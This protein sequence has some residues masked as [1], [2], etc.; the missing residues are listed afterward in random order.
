MANQPASLLETKLQPPRARESLVR[1]R[2]VDLADRVLDVPLALVSAPAGFGKSTVMLAW[3]ERLSASAAVAWIS[4]DEAD[5]EPDHF[6]RY[7]AEAAH[8][9]WEITVG[10]ELTLEALVVELVN[11][12]AALDRPAVLMLDDYQLVESP[13]NHAAVGFLLEHLPANMHLVIGARRDPPLPLARLRSRGRL[14]EVRAD[15]LR[16]TAGEAGELLN[17]MEGLGLAAS[18]VETLEART[19]GWAA[20]LQLAALAARSAPEPNRFV[21]SFGGSHRFVFDYLAEEVLSAQDEETQAFLLRTAV[22]ERL[23]GPLCDA[24]TGLGGSAARLAAL[25]RVNLF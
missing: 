18:Q 8:R 23:S 6:T 4:L 24:V 14:L 25:N 22:L 7:L 20:A 17:G 15:D 10:S 11:H 16:F 21:S 2:L 12:V 13:R 3:F 1:P 9:A 19:E 5:S